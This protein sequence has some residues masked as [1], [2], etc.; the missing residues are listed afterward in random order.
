MYTN[1]H[2]LTQPFRLVDMKMVKKLLGH[3]TTSEKRPKIFYSNLNL[4]QWIAIHHFCFLHP[5]HYPPP[6]YYFTSSLI[7]FCSSP[8]LKRAKEL[9]KQGK[10]ELPPTCGSRSDIE[11]GTYI[12]RSMTR[13]T[14]SSKKINGSC[15]FSEVV[16][17][18]RSFS[19][20]STFG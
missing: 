12:T 5:N 20:I 8:N 3:D 13:N 18:R 7:D 4:Q 16:S 15:L 11:S 2:H 9:T 14:P 17:C 1:C 6:L 19:N 10:I